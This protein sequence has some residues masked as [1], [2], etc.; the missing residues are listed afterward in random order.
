MQLTPISVSARR[1]DQALD[2]ASND[3]NA[4]WVPSSLLK[5][6]QH[7][8]SIKH[9]IIFHQLSLSSSTTTPHLIHSETW[10]H[11]QTYT[12]SQ[13]ESKEIKTQPPQW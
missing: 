10:L 2:K 4:F 3:A 5:L 1:R 11:H 9:C 7:P 6:Q 8:K 12:P 13:V